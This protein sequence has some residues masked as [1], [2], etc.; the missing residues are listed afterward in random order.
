MRLR[1]HSPRPQ[2]M[3]IEKYIHGSWTPYQYYSSTCYVT[4]NKTEGGFV[5]ENDEKR[6]LCVSDYSKIAPLSGGEIVFST[7][8]GRPS[9]SEFQKSKVLQVNPIFIL[10]SVNT[11][12]PQPP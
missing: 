6:A 12:F 10:R 3:M 4:Y 8:Q 2:S 5:P 7:L 11:L 1:F 9:N